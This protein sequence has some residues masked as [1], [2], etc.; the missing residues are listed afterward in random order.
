MISKINIQNIKTNETLL[1]HKNYSPFWEPCRESPLA[2][3]QMR[4]RHTNSDEKVM[5]NTCRSHCIEVRTYI[6]L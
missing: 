1:S 2:V 4:E 6:L 3:A 5:L